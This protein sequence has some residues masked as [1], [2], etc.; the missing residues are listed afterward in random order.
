VVS[1]VL[2]EVVAVGGLHVLGTR[3]YLHVD[4]FHISR[5]LATTPTDQVVI[6]LVWLGALVLGWWTLGSTLLYLLTRV[7]GFRA[8]ARIAERLAPSVIRQVIDRA[9]ATTLVTSV[10]LGTAAPALAREPQLPIT[11]QAPE[12]VQYEPDPAGTEE[13]ETE[14]LAP[15]RGP[16]GRAPRPVDP[17]ESLTKKPEQQG[18]DGEQTQGER[19]P[20]KEQ[21]D[22]ERNEEDP[23]HSASDQERENSESDADD[24]DDGTA[25]KDKADTKSRADRAGDDHNSRTG[26]RMRSGP[27]PGSTYTVRAGDHLWKIATQV[28]S[29]HGDATGRRAVASYWAT[30]VRAATPHLRSGDP[31]L[32]YPGETLELPP[33][34]YRIED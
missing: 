13:A 3:P 18:R 19:K 24:R 28:V 14:P 23:D 17:P 21:Q 33:L 2:F 9:L 20:G 1:L 12:T 11:R 22:E 31:N 34:G 15:G 32:I 8:G 4:W 26:A 27:R 25:D 10:L 29:A 30:L 6:S 7:R 16:R 5:W